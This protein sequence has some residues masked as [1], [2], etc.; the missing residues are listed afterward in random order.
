[1]FLVQ[2]L[3]TFFGAVSN[4]LIGSY[5]GMSTNIICMIRNYINSK[6]KNNMLINN[7]IALTM[8]IIGICVNKIGIIGY[9]PIIASVEYT[10]FAYISKTTQGLDMLYV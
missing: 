10:I 1:M 6:E 8:I 7:I 5:S 9:V 3:N 2:V 4:L